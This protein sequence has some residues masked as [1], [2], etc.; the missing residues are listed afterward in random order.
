MYIIL[1][2]YWRYLIILWLRHSGTSWTAVVVTCAVV[3]LTCFVMCGCGFCNVCNFHNMCTCIYCVLYR[4]YCFVYC[5]F[6]VYVFLLVS[7][8][9]SSVGIETG[10][11]LDGPK[12]ESRWGRNFSHTSRSALGP[13]SFL[14]NGYRVFPGGK[15]VG[16]CWWPPTPS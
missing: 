6:Y 7:G 3:G 12:I 2:L 8:P 11:G 15:A 9:G 16:A 5:F 13:P 14:Y 10:Y 4:L 1:N